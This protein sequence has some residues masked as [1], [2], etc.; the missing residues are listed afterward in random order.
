MRARPRRSLMWWP[1]HGPYTVTLGVRALTRGRGSG[2]A[3]QWTA[4]PLPGGGRG[5]IRLHGAQTPEPVLS[6]L[7]PSLHSRA[8][9][10][11]GQIFLILFFLCP[12]CRKPEST[13]QL[14]FRTGKILLDNST[15]TITG[16]GAP[17]SHS[18]ETIFHENKPCPAFARANYRGQRK[19]GTRGA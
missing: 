17:I 7:A 19:G 2:D 5:G 4:A 3:I 16:P 14:C 15:W 12:G 10:H 8:F 13:K 18:P 11:W 1:P 6:P 9:S